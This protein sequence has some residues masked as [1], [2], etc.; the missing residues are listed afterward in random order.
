MRRT[1]AV[2]MARLRGQ[3]ADF[4][5][6]DLDEVV[7]VQNASHGLNTVLMNFDWHE[8]DIMIGCP[9]LD[10]LPCPALT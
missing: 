8:N 7:I 4:I 2:A 5:N 6:A 3:L 9:L 10:F 1:M